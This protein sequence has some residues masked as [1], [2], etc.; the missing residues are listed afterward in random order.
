MSDQDALGD[1]PAEPITT[2][3]RVNSKDN[4]PISEPVLSGQYLR[5]SVINAGNIDNCYLV[6]CEVNAYGDAITISRNMI[7]FAEPG[8][9]CSRSFLARLKFLFK[10]ELVHVRQKP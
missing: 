9:F 7:H 1:Y 3:I 8:H 10:G 5:N 2:G 4:K 6:N